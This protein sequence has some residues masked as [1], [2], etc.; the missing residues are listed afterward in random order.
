MF[1]VLAPWICAAQQEICTISYNESSHS[2]LD[3][4]YSAVQQQ[5][6][7]FQ[8]EKENIFQQW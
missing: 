4:V 8:A 2:H 1:E 7:I 5:A 3:D 6:T